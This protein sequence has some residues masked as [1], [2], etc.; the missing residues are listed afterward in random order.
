MRLS[1]YILRRILFL[2]PQLLAITLIAF[3]VS[4]LAPGDPVNVNLSQRA[5]ADPA[6]VA[7]FR[8]DRGL[9]KSLIEQYLIY[10]GHLFQ[11]NLGNSIRTNDPVAG[12][13]WQ[14][15]PATIEL[16]TAA[17]LVGVTLGLLLGVFAATRH[18][19]WLDYM[20]QSLALVGI[21]VPVFVLALVGLRLFHV[22]L[23]W[24]P[25]P[26]RLDFDRTGP[27]QVT[28]F[29]TIDS[30]L[31]GQWGTF[32]DAAG[33]LVLPALVLGIYIAGFISR[34]TR[35]AMLEVLTRDY[36]LTA[37]AKGLVAR[38]VIFR[39]ALRN[40]LLPVITNIGLQYGALLTG[41]VL[42][43]SIFAWPG[44]GRYM[45][46]AAT[47]RDFPVIIGV[48]VVIA[49]IYGLVNLVVDILYYFLDPR[50]SAT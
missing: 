12:E 32:F 18:K 20:V 47:S 33:H 39:H 31:A 4:R 29:Y 16:A 34:V 40:A 48:S 28:S 7:A 35:S 5:L 10:L 14:V 36:L 15:L 30:L 1:V 45:F 23:G 21:S 9:D 49:I 46:R 3:V 27:P 43:E 19:S 44:L 6:I 24:V 13:I 26:G 2:G 41:T 25:G 42:T 17:T 50:L 22:Q 37:R 38:V 8:A 11:G